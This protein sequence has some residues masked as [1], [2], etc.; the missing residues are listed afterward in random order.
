MKK[1]VLSLGLIV[2]LGFSLFLFLGVLRGKKTV[3]FEG[4]SVASSA[5][6]RAPL[7]F[8][9]GGIHVLYEGEIS[10][11]VLMEVRSNG[12]RDMNRSQI[13]KAGKVLGYFGEDEAWVD[14]VQVTLTP[15]GTGK[16]TLE[17]AV[18]CGK[19]PRKLEADWYRRAIEIR[20]QGE[21][22]V[23]PKSDRAGG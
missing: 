4:L 19:S 18:F 10:S 5:T 6:V 9:D 1:A 8:R 14:D 12:G 16:K 7:V 23:S 20:K 11:D 13:L 21:Q 17:I 15:L 2:I 3:K 22:F